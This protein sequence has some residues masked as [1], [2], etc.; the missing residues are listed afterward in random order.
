[1]APEDMLTPEPIGCDGPR[2]GEMALE[3]TQN[4]G[5]ASLLQ[6]RRFVSLGPNSDWLDAPRDACYR[7]I[8]YQ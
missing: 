3:P 7:I 6:E 2:F 8:D 5:V 4:C 1:M